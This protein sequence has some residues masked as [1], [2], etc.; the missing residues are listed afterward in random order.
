MTIHKIKELTSTSAPH[1]FDRATLKFFGQTMRS[2]S[3]KKLKMGKYLVSAPMRDSRG[4]S[5]GETLRLFNPKT[6]ELERTQKRA[7]HC[8]GCHSITF[9]VESEGTW[10]CLECGHNEKVTL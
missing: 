4:K 8:F 1:F 7:A 9:H 10:H 2:F 5:V 6:N 3:V